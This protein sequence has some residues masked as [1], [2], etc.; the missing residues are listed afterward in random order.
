MKENMLDVL[1]YIFEHYFEDDVSLGQ[2]RESV[3]SNLVT[4]GFG[5]HTINKVFTWL[6]RLAPDD[7][8]EPEPGPGLVSFRVYTDEEQERIPVE[9][10]GFLLFLEQAGVLDSGMRELVI[11]QAMTLDSEEL[12]LDQ[13]KW[14]AQLVL[15]N[16]LES[17]P[18]IAWVEG[19]V[20]EP[21]GDQLH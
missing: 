3:K 18:S 20:F 17:E 8:D 16:R 12:D 10:R 4:Q 21:V 13:L 2:D 1:M 19:L 15:S 9:C 14:V 11:E 5:E 7:S 6:E